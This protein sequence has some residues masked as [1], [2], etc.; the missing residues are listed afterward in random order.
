M[1]IDFG[2]FGR[3]LGRPYR[4]INELW[5]PSF[6]SQQCLCY[7]PLNLSE[8]ASAI[9]LRAEIPGVGLEDLDLVLT[10]KN[11]IIKGERRVEKGRYFRQ[12]RPAGGFQ[13]MVTLSAP[14]DADH[15]RA[16]LRDGLLT[17][18]L[19]KAQPKSPRKILIQHG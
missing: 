15:V 4:L 7:P 11:L 13:R 16:F 8:N 2:G 18:V 19:P 14:V 3:S 6:L 5:K 10:E 17:V 1:V 9:Y 12:E